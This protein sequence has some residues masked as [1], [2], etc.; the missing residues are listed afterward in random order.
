MN[1]CMIE[2]DLLRSFT[3]DDGIC[4]TE[5]PGSRSFLASKGTGKIK[6]VSEKTLWQ[7]GTP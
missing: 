7:K 6:R 3:N 4:R 2:E 5:F 1:E